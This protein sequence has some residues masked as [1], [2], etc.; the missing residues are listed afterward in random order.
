MAH[1]EASWVPVDPVPSALICISFCFAM[2]APRRPLTDPDTALVYATDAG[3]RIC[4]GCSQPVAQCECAQRARAAKLLAGDG[5]VRVSRE[6]S[7]RGG[8]AV[9]V[10]RGVP[11]PEAEL[12]ALAKALKA[13]CGSGGT[14]K[15]G[16]IEVQGDHRDRVVAHLSARGLKVKRA[17]G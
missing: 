13:A 7:G 16:V 6:T 17:G 1:D 3:G 10:V 8:K 15:D 2:P 11:L 4:P 12:Q 9:T 14:L 5:I